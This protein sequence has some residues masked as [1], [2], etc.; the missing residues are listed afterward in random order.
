M[1]RKYGKK[2]VIKVNP[3]A[4]NLGLIGDSGIGKTTLAKEVCETLVGEDG[5]L[6]LQFGKE[7][8]HDAIAGIMYEEIPDWETF[9]DLV[10]DITENRMTDYKDL[11]VMVYDTIDQLFEIAEPEVIRLHNKDNLDKP[12]KSIKAAFGGYQG[13]EDK[14]IALV[15]EKIWELKG[16]GINMFVIGHTK[17]RTLTDAV[18]GLEYDIVT[19]NMSNKYF[20]AIK[21][22]L[23][24]L[25]VATIDREI[26]KYKTGKKVNNKDVIKGRVSNESRKITFRDDNFNIDSKS[27]F[28]NIIGEIEFDKY[29]FIEAIEN[30]IKAESEK[31]GDVGDLEKIKKQQ[32][33]E[34]EEQ[35]KSVM[36]EKQNKN[37]EKEVNEIIDVITEFVKENKRNKDLITKLSGKSKEMGLESPLKV[38]D[39]EQAKALLEFVNGLL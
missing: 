31:Q 24:A 5:Y 38:K 20:S 34:K 26:A 8:G 13:G 35:I 7:N 29:L 27:R 16:M 39:L 1:A 4:Y 23:H 37:K 17:K 30:A 22:K 36:E 28:A 15:L 9:E 6:V 25:G 14:A 32:E 10:D 11:R 33:K 19:T 12:V 2:N 21:T 3:L 18:T